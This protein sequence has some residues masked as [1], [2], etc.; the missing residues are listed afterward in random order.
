MH[1]TTLFLNNF[2]KTV[3]F[4]HSYTTGY[5]VPFCGI[6][7]KK[8]WRSL[9]IV[10]TDVMKLTVGA[11]PVHTI[12]IYSFLNLWYGVFHIFDTVCPKSGYSFCFWHAHYEYFCHF[13]T[14]CGDMFEL[15]QLNLLQNVASYLLISGYSSSAV[16][17]SVNFWLFIC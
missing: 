10:F 6:L 15:I 8:F 5:E 14:C 16:S 2:M 9:L 17:Q 7:C 12:L 3:N 1:I 4:F 11:L 13:I